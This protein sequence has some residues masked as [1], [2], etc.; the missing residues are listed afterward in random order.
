MITDFSPPP[1]GTLVVNRRSTH[2]AKP[3]R[4][5]WTVFSLQ[6]GVIALAVLL[7]VVSTKN[8]PGSGTAPKVVWV[9]RCALAG[10]VLISGYAT[11]W[12][13][14]SSRRIDAVTAAARALAEGESSQRLEV[15]GSDDIAA[16]GR[17]INH[18]RGHL[19]RQIEW[20]A[21]QRRSFGSLLDELHEG[22]ILAG[23][24]RRIVLANAAAIRFLR[25]AS[26]RRDESL[27]GLSLE[28]CIGQH[29]ALELLQTP[30]TGDLD[31]TETRIQIE[32]PEGSLVL[33]ARACDILI[34]REPDGVGSIAPRIGRLLVLT[35]VSELTRTIQMKADFAANA[36]H[37][38]RT[39][40]AAILAAVETLRTLDL[41]GESGSVHRLVEVIERQS[42]QMQAMVYDLL[43][44]SRLESPQA[45]FEPRRLRMRELVGDLRVSF[46]DEVTRKQLHWTVDIGPGC[47][48]FVASP[49]LL[50]IVLRNLVDNAVRYTETGGRVSITVQRE[51][52]GT[53][54]EI[55]DD[56]CGI[57]PEEQERVFER[58]Y[59]VARSRSGENPGTGLGLS[60][61][62][63]AVAAMDGEVRLESEVGR[64]TKVTVLLPIRP[65]PIA[66]SD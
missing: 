8:Q 12:A 9:A 59:Q 4:L 20:I 31:A 60:I 37:E 44:L 48:E 45:R 51:S 19:V 53:V 47:E 26:P 10:I 38:L 23:P 43:D 39:P 41:T 56:G 22:V 55:A 24:D 50:R 27:E 40:L 58:F 29:D 62:R 63:H 54:I 16:L 30:Q 57:P 13:W 49:E 61:V 46:A 6:A 42:R 15:N 3:G 5:F 21:R 2:P 17:S 7:V 64:G 18:V 14:R 66:L 25:L 65:D 34:P 11:W 35:D 36:S 33:V 1:Q 52:S 28:R 32:S